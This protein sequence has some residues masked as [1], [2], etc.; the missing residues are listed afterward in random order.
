MVGGQR[1]KASVEARGLPHGEAL[2]E[3]NAPIRP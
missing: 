2:P 1:A 3:T